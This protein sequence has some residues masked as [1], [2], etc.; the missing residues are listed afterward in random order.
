MLFFCENDLFI[1]PEP[2]LH[3]KV[4]HVFSVES[5]WGSTQGKQSFNWVLGFIWC[6]LF[7]TFFFL[8]EDVLLKERSALADYKGWTPDYK[9][10]ADTPVRVWRLTGF[11]KQLQR[12]TLEWF[13]WVKVYDS[14]WG[15]RI[16]GPL[17]GI[18]KL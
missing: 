13:P 14:S 11:G 16:L 10:L 9:I 15:P 5:W 3:F 4:E 7:I 6:F 2:N 8:K 18:T 12:D 17:V 1:V